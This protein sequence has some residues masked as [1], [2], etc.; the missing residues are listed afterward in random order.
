LNWQLRRSVDTL[1]DEQMDH[2]R[3]QVIGSQAEYAQALLV[4]TAAGRLAVV[5]F[6]AKW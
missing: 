6:T 5:D 4:A 1:K 3:V 2:G